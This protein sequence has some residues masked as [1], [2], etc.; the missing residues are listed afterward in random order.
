MNEKLWKMS[1]SVTSIIKGP[2]FRVLPSRQ[3]EVSFSIE[4]EGGGEKTEA[5]L[6]AAVEAFRCTYLTSLGAIDADLRRQSYGAVI[7]VRE[8]TWLDTVRESYIQYC[9]SARL[10]AGKLQHLV[11]TFDDGPCYE[12]ICESFKAVT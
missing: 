10:T 2:Y 7:S 3:C 5:L 4:S 9:A 11:I 6:F 8:S 12:F 1:V